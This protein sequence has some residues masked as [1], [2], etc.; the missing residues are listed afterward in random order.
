MKT[1][2]SR[3]V[4]T[5]FSLFLFAGVFVFKV[6]AQQGCCSW[7]DGISHCDSIVGKYVCNDGTYSPSCTCGSTYTYKAPPLCP[8]FA[9][10]NSS[11]ERCECNYGYVAQGSSCVSR[12]QACQNL[13]GYGGEY[14]ILK[15]TCSCRSGYIYNTQTSQCQSGITY[16]SL[17]YGSG[18]TYDYL[19]ENCKCMSTYTFDQSGS[20]CIT[21]DQA[22]QNLNGF[23]S[24]YDILKD[25]CV[26]SYGYV[27]D[28]SKCVYDTSDDYVLPTYTETYREIEVLPTPSPVVKR[29]APSKK[30]V[31]SLTPSTKLNLSEELELGSEGVQVRTLQ[32]GLSRD[33]EVY[34][35]GLITGSFGEKTQEAV[36]KF[37]SK[38]GLAVSGKVDRKTVEAF[39]ELFG[40]RKEITATPAP[41]PVQAKQRKGLIPALWGKLSSYFSSILK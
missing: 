35:L 18:S 36:K 24:R 37:Q 10:Y 16:C 38:Q 19:S 26:C 8:L 39:N 15:D 30:T 28:G 34:P 40:D 31:P 21:K 3:L 41:N 25:T 4:F 22:C 6:E 23:N 2:F 1:L 32:E 14:D 11:T 12:D 33:S 29:T 27:F 5:L 13:L 7:H 9:S 17:K 20:R